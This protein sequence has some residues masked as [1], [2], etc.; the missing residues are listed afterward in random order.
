MSQLL[1]YIKDTDN[2]YQHHNLFAVLK[3]HPLHLFEET[4][5]QHYERFEQIP[6]F[7]ELFPELFHDG[8]NRLYHLPFKL[9]DLLGKFI[10][11][12]VINIPYYALE[13]LWH[14][15]ENSYFVIQVFFQLGYDLFFADGNQ[16][17]DVSSGGSNNFFAMFLQ[18]NELNETK[19]SIESNEDRFFWMK[20]LFLFLFY[21]L[22]RELALALTDTLSVLALSIYVAV[23][24]GVHLVAIVLEFLYAIN[25]LL[26]LIPCLYWFSRVAK[27]L[28]YLSLPYIEGYSDENYNLNLDISSPQVTFDQV[29]IQTGVFRKFL[30]NIILWGPKYLPKIA[31]KLR[32]EPGELFQIEWT[33][34]TEEFVI[35]EEGKKTDLAELK[36]KSLGYD[37]QVFALFAEILWERK[38]R[39]ERQK[40]ARMVIG[41]FHNWVQEPSDSIV[42]GRVGNRSEIRNKNLAP[43]NAEKEYLITEFLDDYFFKHINLEQF[44]AQYAQ[45]IYDVGDDREH[46]EHLLPTA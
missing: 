21:S 23:I 32:P 16:F 36:K 27:T 43:P 8:S 26:P 15:L 24:S 29:D 25:E 28:D 39:G 38:G 10:V 12:L 13:V 6:K 33:I 3:E 35:F 11:Q 31:V 44:D 34:P 18:Y 22:G 40:D 4:N 7:V 1:D 30:H 17:R 37:F 19:P 46:G 20:K 5:Y 14:V 42:Y 9:V 45:Y 41:Q 2:Y